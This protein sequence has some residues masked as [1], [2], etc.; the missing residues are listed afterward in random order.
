M[1]SKLEIIVPSALILLAEALYFFGYP[2][3]CL[4]V[5]ALNILICILGSVIERADAP[6]LQAFSLLS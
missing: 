5:H 6:M 4:G 2:M 3:A 1:R